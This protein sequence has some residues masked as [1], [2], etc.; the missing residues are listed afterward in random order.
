MSTIFDCEKESCVEAFLE[1]VISA[2]GAILCIGGFKII[3]KDRNNLL[4]RVN[5]IIYGLGMI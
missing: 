4:N 3:I 1:T 2:A 5:K